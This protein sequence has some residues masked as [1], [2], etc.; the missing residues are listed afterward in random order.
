MAAP[1]SAT[2][3]SSLTGGS[4]LL[5]AWVVSWSSHSSRVYDRSQS[6]RQCSGSLNAPD[7]IIPSAAVLQ[8]F[9]YASGLLLF[10]RHGRAPSESGTSWR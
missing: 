6:K 10:A 4:W 1:I 3:S 7:R 9:A 8:S 5:L 2:T